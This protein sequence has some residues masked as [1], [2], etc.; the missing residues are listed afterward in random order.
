MPYDSSITFESI[1]SNSYEE[2][3]IINPNQISSN[4]YNELFDMSHIDDTSLNLSIKTI[5]NTENN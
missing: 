5:P 3:F 2:S 1:I 4:N